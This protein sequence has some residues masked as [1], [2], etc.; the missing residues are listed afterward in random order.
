MIDKRLMIVLDVSD[1]PEDIREAVRK[2]YDYPGQ[3]TAIF[4]DVPRTEDILEY[5]YESDEEQKISEYLVSEGI[6]R[7]TEVLIHYWW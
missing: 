4:F 3:N 6:E 5:G 2:W 7:G 1:M